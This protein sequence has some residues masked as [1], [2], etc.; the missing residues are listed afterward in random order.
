MWEAFQ[1]LTPELALP[2]PGFASN[3]HSFGKLET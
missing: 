1:V 2:V 3:H